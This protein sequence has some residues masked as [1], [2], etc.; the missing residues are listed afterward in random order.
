VADHQRGELAAFDP[1]QSGGHAH[2]L[3]G[4][5]LTAG[6][7]EVVGSG[8]EGG[9]LL[10]RRGLHRGEGAVRPLAGVGLHQPRV[11]AW[12]KAGARGHDVGGFPG[13]KQG[14][15][16]QRREPVPGRA[17]CELGGLGA[18]GVIQRHRHLSLEAPFPVIGGLAVAGEVDPRGVRRDS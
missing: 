11:L 17:L 8:E 5:R 18:P 14:A 1:L 12:R 2:L 3:L 4:E 13:P 9:E 10:R 6:E 7:G 16:P 15:G